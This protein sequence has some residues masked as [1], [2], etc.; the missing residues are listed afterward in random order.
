ML[1]YIRAFVKTVQL[2]FKGEMI[3]APA[4]RYPN[5]QAWVDEGVQLTDKVFAIAEQHDI[6]ERA[7]KN[8]TFKLNSR[9]IS[10]QTILAATKHNL[11]ME[12]P[13]LMEAQV[14]HNLTTLYAMNIDDQFRVSQLAAQD[15]LTTSVQVAVQHLADHLQ[16]IPSSENP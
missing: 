16:N 5:L 15:E 4:A 8:L 2:M 7:R 9:T 3:E 14:E 12:Y 11:T 13:M 6:D 10:M 1:K